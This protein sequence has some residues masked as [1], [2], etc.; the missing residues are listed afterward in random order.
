MK[1]KK[2]KKKQA[3]LHFNPFA[4]F[5]MKPIA[6]N[7]LFLRKLNDRN[8]L[9]GCAMNSVITYNETSIDLLLCNGSKQYSS[10]N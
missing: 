3:G 4:T 5:D 6:A 10:K 1:E 8:L 9:R 7:V 2:R